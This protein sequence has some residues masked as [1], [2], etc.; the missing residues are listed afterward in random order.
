MIPSLTLAVVGVDYPNKGKSPARRFEI[1]L[2]R[3]GDPIELHPEPKNPADENAIA[4]YSE[5]D[6][7]LGYLTAERSPLILKYVRDGH[8][9]RAIF[10]S[11][12]SFGAYIRVAFD[13]ER[14]LLPAA[15]AAQQGADDSGFWPDFIPPDD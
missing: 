11:A 12:A 3:P 10:Q 1:A 14:P 7:Q 8:E 5:R 15:P 9:P 6:V 2:C 13:G 4:V